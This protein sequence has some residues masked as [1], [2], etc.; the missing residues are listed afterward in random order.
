[1][2]RYF[3]DTNGDREAS[4]DEIGLDCRTMAEVEQEAVRGLVDMA[5]DLLTT[6]R[7]TLSV[8][9]RD[10]AGRTVL[11]ATLVLTIPLP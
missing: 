7:R 11:K 4:T 1:M 10:E 8:S 9:V 3:F 6:S 5:H 2:A